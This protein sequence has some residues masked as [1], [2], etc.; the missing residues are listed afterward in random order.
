MKAHVEGAI[1]AL[2]GLVDDKMIR[3]VEDFEAR[4][5]PLLLALGR[6]LVSL[7]LA[8]RVEQEARAISAERRQAPAG[9]RLTT[10]GT[11]CGRVA[12]ASPYWRTSKR[13]P[14]DCAADVRIGLGKGGFTPAVVIGVARLAAQMAFGTVR[15]EWGEMYGWAPSSRAVL[16]IVDAAGATAE[17]F[18]KQAPAPDDD[19]EV[20]VIQADCKGAP[21]ITPDEYERRTE[22]RVAPPATSQRLRR[23]AKRR[24]RVR[25][26]RTSGKRAKN[27]KMAVVAALYTLK[28]RPDGTWEG[29]INK[30][31]IATFGTHDELFQRLRRE[32]IKRGY[33]KKRTLFLADGAKPIWAAQERHLPN[34]EV[35]IDWFHIVEKIWDAGECLFREGTP[36]LISW[37]EAQKKRLR[38][39]ALTPL[40]A[41]LR[42]SHD[43]IARTGPG[44]KGKRSRLA[45]V[46]GYLER[47]RERLRYAEMRSEGF[48]IGTGIIEGTV[49]HL[50]GMRLDGSGMRW[51][52]ERAERILA[53]RCILLSDLWPAFAAQ[54][55]GALGP[56]LAACPHPATPHEAVPN[57]A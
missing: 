43:A 52:R 23:R 51:G 41:E 30:R 13:A 33:G 46:L 14:Q 18:L 20:L 44:N 49:R 11:L 36:E 27:A 24:A 54:L 21:M 39:G 9:V 7:F 15:R 34:V 1:S 38:R 19:G 42:R 53:L 29:P 40:L 6:S 12:Y 56:R 25:P 55:S 10:I 26:R 37:V 32:A 3:R 8:L 17:Q 16:R 35:C 2:R 57:A 47:H 31:L 4:S 5:W 28:R 50:V 45:K 22:P 48:D